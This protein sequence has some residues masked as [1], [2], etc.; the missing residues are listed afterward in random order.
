MLFKEFEVEGRTYKLA[1]NT[2]SIME[3]EK[4][5]GCNPVAIF[6][7]EGTTIP[8]ITVMIQ[9][10]TASLQ[11]FEHGF[12]EKEAAELFDKWLEESNSIT[13]VITVIVEIDKASGLIR[14]QE[15][16]RKN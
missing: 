10:L 1:L 13:D 9:I 8:T 2:R 12:T 15:E 7:T 14:T 3:L 11:K 6:G 5:I 16:E 4:K